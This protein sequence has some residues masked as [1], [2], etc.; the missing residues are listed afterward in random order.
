MTNLQRHTL[1]VIILATVTLLGPGP[2]P[3][4]W[5]AERAK[6]RAVAVRP[7]ARVN[8][9]VAGEEEL[10]TLKGV[11]RATARRIIEYREAH[12]EF[13][14]PEDVGKVGRAGKRIWEQN[15]D[16]IVVK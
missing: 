15:R 13:K 14:T 3:G 16:R 7:N 1:W 11:G 9:N 5:A 8:I 2:S 10:T 4:S 12:G 6:E